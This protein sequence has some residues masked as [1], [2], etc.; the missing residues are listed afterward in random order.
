MY[1]TPASAWSARTTTAAAA[2]RH[3][4]SSVTSGRGAPATAASSSSAGR[5][6]DLPPAAVA[7]P[8]HGDAAP[9]GRR[10]RRRW[11]SGGRSKRSLVVVRLLRPDVLRLPA[12]LPLL[13]RVCVAATEWSTCCPYCAPGWPPRPPCPP[14]AARVTCA[15]AYRSDGPI[16][17]TCSSYVVRCC[18]S[19]S[20]RCAAQDALREDPHAFVRLPATC[21]ANSRQQLAWRNSASPSFHSFACRS[22]VFG[23]DAI[24]KFATASRSACT[25]ARGRR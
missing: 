20:G 21:S 13:P 24:V 5:V 17:S 23:V 19:R 9:A 8:L 12:G 25:A 2:A 7:V 1:S 15:V 11:C 10:G 6:A 16:S 14:R 22:N 4:H 18:P 3:P